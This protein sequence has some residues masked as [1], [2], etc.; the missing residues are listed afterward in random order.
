M[1]SH[2]VEGN[3]KTSQILSSDTRN[4]LARKNRV[5]AAAVVLGT[6]VPMRLVKLHGPNRN[7]FL[8][9]VSKGVNNYSNHVDAEVEVRVES[10][11]SV[12]VQLSTGL[13]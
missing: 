4:L 8:A 5:K 3:V 7:I 6:R 10:A 1:S 12:K 13:G 9:Q 2:V 11:I